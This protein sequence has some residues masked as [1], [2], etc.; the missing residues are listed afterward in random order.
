[1]PDTK[2]VFRWTE[3]YSVNV[4]VLDQQH[5]ELFEVVNELEQALRVGEGMVAIDRI[6]DKLVTYAGVHFAAEE[7]LLERHKFPGLP[8]HRIQHDMFRKMVL[9]YIEKHR[10]AK[11]GVAVEVL[12]FLQNWLKQHVQKTDKQYSTFLN[13]RGIR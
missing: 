10:A 1:M 2:C 8:I 9:T 13:Q 6:L 4:E 7:S 11:S 3:A 5:Q 12:L